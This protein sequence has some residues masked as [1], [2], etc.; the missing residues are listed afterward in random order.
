VGMI[1]EDWELKSLST[2]G[3]VVRGSSPR[4][5]GDKRFYG[6]S[7]PRLMV[8]DITRDKHWVTP[9]ID[10]LTNEGAKHSRLCRAGTLTVVCSG[11]PTAVGLPSLLA[12]DACVHDGI[13]A[14]LQLDKRISADF[15][16]HQLRSLQ[17]QL[18]SAATHGGTFVN[19]TT[20]GFKAFK[21]ALPPTKA[22]QD[23][24]ADALSDADALVESL[25]QLISKKR[26]LKHGV[27]QELLTGKKRLP[28][29]S[30]VWQIHRFDDLFTVL[31]NASNS[32][33]ELSEDGEVAYVHYGD[34]HTHP[35]AFLNPI[36]NRTYISRQKVRTIPRLAD[37]DLLMA[38]A[39]EDTAAIGKAVEIV[40]LDAREAVAGLHT[41]LLRGDKAKLA[42]GFKAYLQFLPKVRAALVR[43]A[44]GVSVYGITKSGVKAIEVTIPKPEEQTAIVAILSDMDAEIAVLEAKLTKVRQMKQ[45]MMQQL[46]TGSVRLV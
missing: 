38:D 22:E 21:V 18:H 1:P 10:F 32:R 27:M 2:L 8:E 35:T 6:G 34:I 19:L 36:T 40:G 25:E 39:S 28:G 41:M 5:K 13:L 16:F 9:S 44:T 23:A 7:I 14:L 29:F 20:D 24:V 12:V 37:G 43:L 3:T 42:D 26:D 45:G 30:G 31:R 4:P 33:S 15:L 46:L 17:T 11:T